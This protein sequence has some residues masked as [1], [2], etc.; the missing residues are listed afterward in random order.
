MVQT[1]EA[2]VWDR[3]PFPGIQSVTQGWDN[4]VGLQW[5]GEG[6]RA[7][8]RTTSYRIHHGKTIPNLEN[9]GAE[10]ENKLLALAQTRELNKSETAAK[11]MM[12]PGGS[13]QVEQ[14][15]ML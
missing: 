14:E 12:M 1:S 5:P 13:N 8:P 9:L 2:K 11:G 10:V 6:L 7:C 15:L 4:T 3:A